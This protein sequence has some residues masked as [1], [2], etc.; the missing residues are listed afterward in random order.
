MKNKKVAGILAAYTAG[1]ATQLVIHAMCVS[2]MYT[3]RQ[4]PFCLAAGFVVLFAVICG[5]W[6]SNAKAEAKPTHEKT[7]LD[8]AKIPEEDVEVIDPFEVVKLVKKDNANG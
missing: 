4:I 6:I 7:Y 8:W 1:Q 2:T 3:Y 5:V